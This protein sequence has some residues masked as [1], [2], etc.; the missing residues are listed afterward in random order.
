EIY[1]RDYIASQPTPEVTFAWQGGE[2]TILGVDFYRRAVALQQQYAGGKRITNTFQ[3]NG[4]LL[5]DT[6]GA[7]LH[8][9]AFLVGI[10]IDGPQEYHNR[11]RR[12]KGGGPS[13]D[14]VMRGLRILQKHQ[15]EYNILT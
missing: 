12:D 10:S 1:V 2:P 15:V 5:D 14:R 6:W 13:F 11:H 9:N 7:F 3:T 8:E 4:T